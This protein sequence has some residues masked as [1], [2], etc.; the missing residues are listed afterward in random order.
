MFRVLGPVT[1]S[2]DGEDVRIGAAKQRMVS[3]RSPS[4]RVR[5]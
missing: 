4:M 2:L 5:R 3:R 1:T